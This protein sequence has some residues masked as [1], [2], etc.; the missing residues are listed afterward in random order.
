MYILSYSHVNLI[1]MD[2]T[3]LSPNFNYNKSSHDHD[4]PQYLTLKLITL[5]VL[6]IVSIIL[7]QI[8]I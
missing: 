5:Y 6:R 4:I 8:P 2:A 3:S 7:Q 1:L